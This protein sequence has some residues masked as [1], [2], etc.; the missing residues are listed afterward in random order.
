M[1]GRF[2]VCA[3]G[4]IL[5]QSMLFSRGELYRWIDLSAILPAVLAIASSAKGVVIQLAAGHTQW[6]GKHD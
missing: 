6:L 5:S 2:S 4:G 3:A 1:R